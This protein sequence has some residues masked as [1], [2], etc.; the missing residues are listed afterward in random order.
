MRE[1]TLPIYADEAREVFLAELPDE[2]LTCGHAYDLGDDHGYFICEL[3]RTQP[4]AGIE[5]LG[6]VASYEA[7][8]RLVELY[9]LHVS[10]G[11]PRYPQSTT[12]DQ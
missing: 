5:I 1:I 11:A 7:A 2:E 8:L 12:A 4:S 6:K 3:D 10:Q 9:S